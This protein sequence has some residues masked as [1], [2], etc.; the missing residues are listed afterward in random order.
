[1]VYVSVTQSG[2]AGPFDFKI[3][4]KDAFAAADLFAYWANVQPS[5]YYPIDNDTGSEAEEGFPIPYDDED[6]TG[7]FHIR[8]TN[9]DT[10]AHTYTVT[11][12]Y[13]EAP[14]MQS[15]GRPIF[16]AGLSLKDADVGHGVTDVTETTNFFHVDI[17]SG[18]D[19]GARVWGFSDTVGQRPMALH[20]VFGNTDPTDTIP[21][22]AL[23]GSKRS[24]TGRAVLG[25][26]ETVLKII[27]NTTDLLTMLG[28][29]AT[30]MVRLGLGAAA[31]SVVPLIVAGAT[32]A[33]KIGRVSDSTTRGLIS[34]NGSETL[35]GHIG[36]TSSTALGTLIFG[37]PTGGGHA[38]RI[39]NANVLNLDATSL[40]IS[41]VGPHAIGGATD[42]N[43]Q[44]RFTGAFSSPAGSA[45][46]IYIDT[47]LSPAASQNAF[48]IWN[49]AGIT[50][51]SSGVHS[52]LSGF[53]NDPQFTNAA[54]TATDVIGFDQISFTAP[55]GTTTASSIRVAAPTAATTN[56]A[57]NVTSGNNYFGA[58]LNFI[59]DT[60]NINMTTGLTIN[61]GAAD[62]EIL[63][64][65]S[66]DVAHG[67]TSQT[68]T[69][70]F[71]FVS[72][73]AGT[74]GGLLVAGFSS[75]TTG[76]EL[77]GVH[78]TDVTTKLTT[79]SGAV[80]INGALKSGTGLTAIGADG[81]IAVIRSNGTTRFIFDAEGSA[82]ADVEW[83]AFD[84]YDDVGMLNTLDAVFVLRK[85][86]VNHEFTAAMQEN[87]AFLQREG[88]VNFYD[89]GPRAML[90]LT[91]MHMLEVGAIR[92]ISRKVQTIEDR[93]KLYEKALIGLGVNPE[94]LMLAN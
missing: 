58:G 55:V 79:S 34:F 89:E 37:V 51:A 29:G 33:I 68:E 36:I 90:N 66:S 6:A 20:G 77:T 62:T 40:T 3:F 4:K 25:N 22:I 45:R 44:T 82:H 53:R 92:Q 54:A 59:N 65:K 9:K 13:I 15:T 2:T 5:L 64:L 78:T 31:D 41:P 52:I 47:A 7:E 71:G 28:D 57:L 50:E 67:I 18:T 35:T 26:A 48:G 81:N 32:D 85:G 42:A 8:I 38:M 61:Q 21:A 91:R 43:S 76:L 93:C 87:K 56:W 10:A 94:Q 69:D 16:R 46:A 75:A 27:N 39:N 83:V 17:D 86:A 30:Q 84:K 12:K 74:T 88:I 80:I 73:A 23:V 11:I 49:Q 72:K 1:M 70:S 63:T 19:G 14:Q 60:S 24:G